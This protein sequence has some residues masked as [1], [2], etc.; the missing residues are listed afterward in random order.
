ML[1][2]FDGTWDWTAVG[3]LALA[4][5]QREIELSR[6]EVEEA[7]RPVLMPLADSRP[8]GVVETSLPTSPAAR[9][10]FL[11]ANHQDSRIGGPLGR[12]RAIG[13]AS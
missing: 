10:M 9:P 6:G 7:H 4:Q 11:G 5:T 1:T 12:S 8:L 2:A 3:T 13:P